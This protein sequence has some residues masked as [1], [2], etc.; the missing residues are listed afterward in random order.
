MP[1]PRG[2]QVGV[3]TLTLSHIGFPFGLSGQGG[4]TSHIAF[5]IEI[6]YRVANHKHLVFK[7][8][9][10]HIKDSDLT[11]AFNHFGPHMGVKFAVFFN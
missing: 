4:E 5:P 3:G 2:R 6:V 7:A 9:D 10:L 8:V 1:F 11:L